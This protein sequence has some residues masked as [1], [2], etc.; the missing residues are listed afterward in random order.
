VISV[1]GPLDEFGGGIV[2]VDVAE[3][4]LPSPAK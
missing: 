4:H 2:V 1:V 3:D